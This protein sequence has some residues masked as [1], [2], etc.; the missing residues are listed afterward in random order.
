MATTTVTVGIP[1]CA[2]GTHIER[3]G[4]T[5]VCV[6]GAS[7]SFDLSPD[8]QTQIILVMVIALKL[9]FMWVTN[10]LFWKIAR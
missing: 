3:V 8:F 5:E 7:Y 2:A 4:G 10:S 6:D 9:G 1:P